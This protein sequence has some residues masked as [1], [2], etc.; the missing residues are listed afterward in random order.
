MIG[1]SVVLR[2]TMDELIV[3]VYRV[4]DMN[5]DHSLAHEELFQCL[6]GC[7]VPGYGVERDEIEDAEKD[8]VETCMRKLDVNRDGQITFD[9]YQQA[10]HIDPL[11]LQACGEC[12][13]SPRAAATFLATMT[14]E[15]RSY[16]SAYPGNKSLH[17]Q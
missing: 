16:S 10:V 13:P 6:K 12:L 7:I 4:Y 14:V 3:F 1:L 8:I 17:H 11:L 2:G 15:Y 9:D 5:G